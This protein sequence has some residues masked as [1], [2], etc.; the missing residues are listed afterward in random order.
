[1]TRKQGNEY[2][3]ER[4]GMV[5]PNRKGTFN[6]AGS[7]CGSQGDRQKK[8]FHWRLERCPCA[9]TTFI[10]FQREVSRDH[11]IGSVDPK[12]DFREEDGG[13]QRGI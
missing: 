6:H 4:K 5:K 2:P 8:I 1:M 3:A 13:T 12:K 9:C 7:M 10:T 11:K